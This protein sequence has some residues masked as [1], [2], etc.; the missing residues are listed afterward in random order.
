MSAASAAAPLGPAVRAVQLSKRYGDGPGAVTALDGVDLEVLRGQFL[1]VMGPSGSGKSTLLHLIAGLDH[2]TG[3]HI[4]VGAVRLDT[5][6]QNG[7]ARFRRRHVGI[8][9][10]FFNLIPSLTVE[11]NVALPLLLEGAR[12]RNEADRVRSLLASLRIEAL[13]AKQP[14]MLSG[15]EMQRVAIAR[16]LIANPTL[17]LADE[18]TG[19]LDSRSG[20][21]ILATLRR[22]SDERGVTTLLVTHD[23]RAASYADRVVVIRD[24][25]LE[26]DLPAHQFGTDRR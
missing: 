1:A 4:E 25:R 11:E 7:A 14:A 13:G 5:L 16:A 3:G 10:Q 19:N 9:F 24:G 17:I 2:P 22:I 15:G 21:E 20:E 18:P 23:L 26:D 8:V 12:F 6:D